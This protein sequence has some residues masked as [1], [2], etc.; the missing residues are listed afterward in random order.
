MANSSRRGFLG[1]ATLAAG[2]VGMEAAAM[3]D[4]RVRG[5]SDPILDGEKL[6][7]FKF[8]MEDQEGRVTEGGSAKEATI[9]QL[10]DLQGL[11]GVSMRL[12][13]GGIRE[14]HWH[15]IAAEWAF[16]IKGQVRTT[17][18]GPDCSRR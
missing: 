6:P 4:E 14:L 5:H 13:P 10:P 16:V 1:A 18:I 7:S 3:A 2:A 9:K 8:A 17:V 12:K 11:A 15:A